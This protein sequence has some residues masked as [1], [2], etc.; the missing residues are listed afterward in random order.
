MAGEANEN[1]L[2]PPSVYLPLELALEMIGVTTGAFA[3][4]GA[5]SGDGAAAVAFAATTWGT[6]V[7]RCTGAAALV[8]SMLPLK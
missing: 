4:A 1:R 7:G 2:L 3:G 8:M 5:G 6:A